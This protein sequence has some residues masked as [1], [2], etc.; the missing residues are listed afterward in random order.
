MSEWAAGAGGPPGG[1]GQGHRGEEL[2]PQLPRVRPR[3]HRQ[4]GQDIVITSLKDMN[5]DQKF[6]SEFLLCRQ[7]VD[8]KY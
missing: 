8:I 4:Q 6:V 7:L 5:E 1:G 2:Q 3:Q